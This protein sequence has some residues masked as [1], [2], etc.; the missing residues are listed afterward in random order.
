MAYFLASWVG[1]FINFRSSPF[2]HKNIWAMGVFCYI[3]WVLL[4]GVPI[5]VFWMACNCSFVPFFLQESISKWF[6]FFLCIPLF[7]IS[8]L[9]SDDAARKGQLVSTSEVV[10]VTSNGMFLSVP[11]RC[12][13]EMSF[14]FVLIYDTELVFSKLTFLEAWI[15]WVALG[16]P[17]PP[18]GTQET[19]SQSHCGPWLTVSWAQPLLPTPH[20]A[21][22]S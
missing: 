9:W 13:N 7:L 5:V 19:L 8:V 20:T 2:N 10:S 15:L 21:S 14:P 6:N 18:A 12:L 22:S 3:L 4:C 1:H 11:H 16:I 17:V